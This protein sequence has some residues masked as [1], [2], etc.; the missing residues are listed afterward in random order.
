MF[1]GVGGPLPM[2]SSMIAA[3]NV[4]NSAFSDIFK[5]KC[6]CFVSNYQGL[7]PISRRCVAQERDYEPGDI[8]D[9]DEAMIQII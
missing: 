7:G 5:R 1:V 8:G 9:E 2:A 3:L 4:G 6:R